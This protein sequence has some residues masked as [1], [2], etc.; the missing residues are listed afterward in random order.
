MSEN[1]TQEN[2]TNAHVESAIQAVRSKGWDVNPYTVADELK[3]LP[4]DIAKKPEFMQLLIHA[5]G[6]DVSFQTTP[7]QARVSELEAEVRNLQDKLSTSQELAAMPSADDVL[8]EQVKALL[9]SESDE[10]VKHL[11]KELEGA[12]AQVV[13]LE[14]DKIDLTRSVTGLE[15]INE[16]LNY[17]M[18]ELEAESVELKRQLASQPAEKS[19]RANEDMESINREM[20]HR[21]EDL[22]STNQDLISTN[23]ANNEHIA[24]LEAT[25]NQHESLIL[26]LEAK[27]AELQQEADMLA[28]QLQNAFHVGYQKGAADNTPAGVTPAQTPEARA[29]QEA[30]ARQQVQEISQELTGEFGAPPSH[31]VTGDQVVTTP[32]QYYEM[33][34]EVPNVEIRN[35]VQS[36]NVNENPEESHVHG[37]G[38]DTDHVLNFAKTGPYVASTFNPLE[39]LSWRDLETVYSM[40]VL[41]IRDFSRNLT[42]YATNTDTSVQSAMEQAQA[43]QQQPSSAEETIQPFQSAPGEPAQSSRVPR[44]TFPDDTIQPNAGLT[45][46]TPPKTPSKRPVTPF[47][48]ET[49]ETKAFSEADLLAAKTQYSEVQQ[50]LNQDSQSEFHDEYGHPVGDD[51]QL[52]ARVFPDNETTEPP[53]S[54]GALDFIDELIDLD[55]LDIF[56]SLEDLAELGNIDVLNEPMQINFDEMN[57]AT[58]ETPAVDP[59]AKPVSDTEL[60]DLLASRI[61]SASQ[62]SSGEQAVRTPPAPEADDDTANKKPIPGLTRKFVGTKAAQGAAPAAASGETPGSPNVASSTTNASVLSKHIPQE[63]RKACMI[64]GVRPEDLT[65]ELVTK[66]WKKQI[67]QI[68]PD[69]QGGDT[70][71]SIYLNTAKDTLLRW[72]DQN[73]PKLGGKFGSKAGGS[74][75]FTGKNKSDDKS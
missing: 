63:I 42:D 16:A 18:R 10:Q 68:H 44:P 1:V 22:I 62:E 27:L 4:A 7:D 31:T 14:E 71:S 55:K 11:E 61:S 58:S 49:V 2:L 59:A 19:S 34:N 75:P 57:E 17:R 47:P 53:K 12:Y 70:E 9:S 52:E 15:K 8:N 26:E 38:A 40:G 36:E 54:E 35:Q 13:S 67:T 73:A 37:W 74:S 30:Q 23:R 24:L 60:R 69:L 64:L 45:A 33:H 39:S 25:N 21:L 46:V 72:L 50:L 20:A 29:A 41:S 3:V 56:D 32:G 28:L 5:R 43:Q 48:D 66:E 6:G 51:T 65:K